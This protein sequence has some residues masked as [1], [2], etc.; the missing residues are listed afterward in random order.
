[1]SFTQIN[2]GVVMTVK[3]DTVSTGVLR[4]ANVTS[5]AIDMPVGVLTV[6]EVM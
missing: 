2:P 1:V 3:V 6:S 5:S 4:I